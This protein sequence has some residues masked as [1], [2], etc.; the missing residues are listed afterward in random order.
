MRLGGTTAAKD[1]EAKAEVA[2]STPVVPRW[3]PTVLMGMFFVAVARQG[4]RPISDPDTFWHLRLGRDVLEARSVNSVTQPWSELSDQSWVPTQ[5]TTEVIM[6]GAEHAGGLPAVAWLFTVSLLA[7]VL[8]VHQIARQ[9]ADPVPAAFA[10]GLTIAAMAASLSPRPHM[11]TY[12]FVGITMSA[13]LATARDLRP[14][15]WLI[16]LTWLW[17]MSHGMWFVGPVVGAAVL[18]GL[19]LDRR[20]SPKDALRLATVPIASVVV[21]ALTPVGP[22]LLGAPFAV[23]GVGSFITEWQPASFR[24]PSPAAA[25]VM[26][27]I[28]VIAWSRSGSR[29]SW[30]HVALLAMSTGWILLA[31]RTVA[32]GALIASPLL[33]LALQGFLNR[34]T[35]SATDRERWALRAAALVITMICAAIVPGSAT[36]P[37]KV[38]TNLSATL[39]TLD[40]GVVL[41]AYEVGGWLR[42]KHPEWEPV[43]DGMTEAYSLHHLRNYAR[44]T[45]V[46]PGW[47]EVVH[48]WGAQVALVPHE[49]PLALALEERLNWAVVEDD[50]PYVLMKNPETTG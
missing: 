8:L 30:T 20:L 42:W 40:P 46:A 18:T 9:V 37:D 26:V 21:S 47:E 17:A 14:R 16:P 48:D 3:L 1:R 25:A 10:T 43:V 32:L 19:V 50:G 6:A 39:D 24:S 2:E 35:S 29:I 5:W 31:T 34:R 41:N 27:A 33:A 7:L 45:A 23:A 13:W 15:W 38:P 22:A 12:L 44:V 4:V 11:V 49:S 36:T 28:V